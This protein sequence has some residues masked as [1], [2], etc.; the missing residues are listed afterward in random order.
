MICVHTQYY[1]EKIIMKKV[2]FYA[3]HTSRDND[4]RMND[5][6]N[7]WLAQ[8]SRSLRWFRVCYIL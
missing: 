4:T 3:S 7:D 6:L 5:W 8:I 2:C 1:S